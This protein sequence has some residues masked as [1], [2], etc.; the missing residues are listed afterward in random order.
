MEKLTILVDILICNYSVQTIHNRTGWLTAEVVSQHLEDAFR[1]Q[2]IW[3]A[4]SQ[5][6]THRAFQ[7]LKN[8]STAHL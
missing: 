8:D 2:L 6:R 5:S 3:F 4:G 7:P 1:Q